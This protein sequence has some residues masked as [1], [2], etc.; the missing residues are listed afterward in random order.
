M[1][2]RYWD[3]DMRYDSAMSRSNSRN[4][5]WGAATLTLLGVC[6][7]S[8]AVAGVPTNPATAP[9]TASPPSTPSTATPP[10]L[11]ATRLNATCLNATCLDSLRARRPHERPA[12]HSNAG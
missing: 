9:T 10:R 4:R 1:T 8:T 11:N 2:D 3:G 5:Y 6:C 12:G 7:V